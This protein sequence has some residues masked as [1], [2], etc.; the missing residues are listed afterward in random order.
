[1]SDVLYIYACL[2]V[3]LF[4]WMV[5][6]LVTSLLACLTGWLVSWLVGCVVRPLENTSLF[7]SVS[8]LRHI[9]IWFVLL[10]NTNLFQSVTLI[11]TDIITARH[12]CLIHSL[13]F[14][15]FLDELAD[16]Y[17]SQIWGNEGAVQC[18]LRGSVCSPAELRHYNSPVRNRTPAVSRH[19]LV[20]R[21]SGW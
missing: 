1:M 15:G 7:Q 18:N 14:A 5:G 21:R 13:F 20:V 8:K 19:G 6:H 9:I 2:F 4:T 12:R 3:R 11:T 16:Y 17:H 10:K